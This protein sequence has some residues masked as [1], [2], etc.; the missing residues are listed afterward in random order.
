MTARDVDCIVCGTCVADVLVRP[1]PL[2]APIGGGRLIHVE[3]LEVTTGGLVCNTGVA[4]RR[5]GLGVAAAGIVGRDTWGDVI[6]ARL[7]AEGIDTAPLETR[8]DVGTSTTAVLIDPGGERSFAHHVGAC[9]AIDLGFVRG[10]A[11]HFA[12]SRLALVGYLGLLPGLEPDLGAALEAV[13]A[14]GCTV[15][16]ETAGSGGT[17]GQLAPALPHVDVYVPSLDEAVHQTGLRDPREIVACYRGHGARGLVGVKLGTRGVLLSPAAGEW[18][19][20]PCVAA[21]GAVADTTG[22]GDSF[23]G[24]LLAGLLR[25]MPPRDAGLL[26][27]ATA[28]CCVTGLGATAG[29]RSFED[30]ARLAGL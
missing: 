26:G 1:V 25:G 18:L 6:R 17:L 21:P 10:L 27:A 14:A 23:L 9:G 13:A 5:L 7:A 19:D 24:G 8:A 20:V 12:R 29:L 11:G 16:L 15:A 28:A 30:T 3:P 22:A 4:L 2:G